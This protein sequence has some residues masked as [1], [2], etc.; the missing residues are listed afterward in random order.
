MCEPMTLLAIGGSLMGSAAANKAANAQ[1]EYQ[2]Q[3]H[4]ENRKQADAAA[5]N[6]YAQANAEEAQAGEAAAQKQMAN[7]L[8]AREQAARA[9]VAAAQSG[10]I[11]NTGNVGA[12]QIIRQGLEANTQ[13]GQNLARDQQTFGLQR[14]GIRNRQYSRIQSVSKGRGKVSTLSGLDIAQAGIAG[15]G[16]YF[17][18]AAT[19]ADNQA[20]FKAKGNP[21]KW[22]S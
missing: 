14:E 15:A 12:A 3:L 7:D 11:D 6:E 18:N 5:I 20:K 19:G 13:I 10:A 4:E 22:L 21:D 17:G 1:S 8:M 2:D 9:N 16:Q